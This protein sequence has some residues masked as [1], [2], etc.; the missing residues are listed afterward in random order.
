MRRILATC[1]LLL[2]AGA[3]AVFAA[4]AGDE[5]DTYEVRAIFDNAAF[6]NPNDQVKIS[7]VP[8][9]VVDA[10]EITRVDGKVKAA[11]DFSITDSAFQNFTVDAG[12]TIRPQSLISERFLECQPSRPHRPGDVPKQLPT[13]PEGEP[14]AGRHLVTLDHTQTPVDLDLIFDIM[15]LPY[16]QRFSIILN[17]LGTGLAGNGKELGEV[18]Q[19]ANPALKETDEVIQLLAAQNQELADI[20]QNSDTVLAP[21][22]RDRERVAD[23]I[24]QANTVARAVAD[25]R[26]DLE[27]GFERLPVF[28][29]ELNPTLLRLGELA[30]QSVPV[31]RDVR[32]STPDIYALTRELGPFSRVALPAIRDL[33]DASRLGSRALPAILPDVQDLSNFAVELRPLVS[34]LLT[35]LQSLKSTGG[36][37]QLLLYAYFQ[38]LAVN[39]YDSFSHYLRAGL[40]N[41]LTC[42]AL[43]GVQATGSP[44]SARFPSSQFG[45]GGGETEAEAAAKWRAAAKVARDKRKDAAEAGEAQAQQGEADPAQGVSGSPLPPAGDPPSDPSGTSRAPGVIEQDPRASGLDYLLGPEGGR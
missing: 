44:C 25:R 2:T 3:V 37:E 9:G 7:G 28:F 27:A 11:V 36:I 23:F 16:A 38:P 35:L 34:N 10:V 6:L 5:G 18:V 20:A 31:L 45:P 33:G 30:D 1:L 12:C 32:A 26:A 41:Q 24:V 4:G 40:N 14:G 13:I 19:R 8:V 42:P 39:G 22:A 15:R 43:T 29:E 21:L 17:E